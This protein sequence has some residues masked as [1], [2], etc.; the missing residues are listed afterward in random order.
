MYIM[1]ERMKGKHDNWF[2]IVEKLSDERCYLYI[3]VAQHSST[4][5]T[6]YSERRQIFNS[7]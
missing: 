2:Q 3:C 5:V 4:R 7:I 1:M 6:G